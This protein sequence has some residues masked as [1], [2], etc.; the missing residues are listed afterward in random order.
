MTK[1]Y[2][3]PLILLLSKFSF[4]Q[5]S[6]ENKIGPWYTL[7]ATHTISTKWSVLT[8]LQ[9]IN[10]EFSGEFNR[11]QIMTGGDYKLKKNITLSAGYQ[12]FK[13]EPYKDNISNIDSEN[14]L[15]QQINYKLQI[16]KIEF[17]NRFRIDERWVKSPGRNFF[18]NRIR[19]RAQFTYPINK[20]WYLDLQDE[21]LL[22]LEN[23]LY[24]FNRIA[25]GG[26]Y[27]VNRNLKI[28]TRYS[29]DRFYS[30]TVQN[31]QLAILIKTDLRKKEKL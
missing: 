11:G 17:S 13:F 30:R 27:F 1:I 15:Y 9:Y 29:F 7:S 10:H 20:N 25:L 6:T 16:G 3:F 21:I 14:R 8:Q 18:Q 2:Y 19:Y 12:Y 31:L 23:N 28:Q 4:S 26:G 22:K 24:H 5:K